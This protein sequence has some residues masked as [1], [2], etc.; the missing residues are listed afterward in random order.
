MGG[1]A[2]SG[3]MSIF[4]HRVLELLEAGKLAIV[5]ERNL[6]VAFLLGI[7]LSE[8]RE[9]VLAPERLVLSRSRGLGDTESVE[10]N[11]FVF[12]RAQSHHGHHFAFCELG[13]AAGRGRQDAVPLDASSFFLT[14]C[15]GADDDAVVARRPPVLDGPGVGVEI[16]RGR[17]ARREFIGNRQSGNA[18]LLE[19]SHELVPGQGR[20][21]DLSFRRLVELVSGLLV[22]EEHPAVLHENA[23][24]V[25]NQRVP[26]DLEDPEVVLVGLGEHEVLVGLRLHDADVAGVGR[27]VAGSSLLGEHQWPLLVC[28]LARLQNDGAAAFVNDAQ[29]ELFGQSANRGDDLAVYRV[30]GGNHL[31]VR[32]DVRNLDLDHGSSCVP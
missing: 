15:I 23:D 7:G 9:L 2:F 5:P 27:A 19:C 12:R 21:E 24:F 8:Q 11:A 16:G 30:G 4:F 32:T 26:L 13:Q 10:L 1:G 3:P 22:E 6:F 17:P 18:A 28:R 31:T 29:F 14:F 25:T 20:G